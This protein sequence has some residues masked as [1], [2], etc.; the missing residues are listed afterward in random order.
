LIIM[1]AMVAPQAQ[2]H[3]VGL[4]VVAAADQLLD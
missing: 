4:V 3:S 1:A 2:F